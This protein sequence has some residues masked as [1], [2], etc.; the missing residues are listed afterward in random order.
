MHALAEFLP[1]TLAVTLSLIAA[2]G[3]IAFRWN[4]EAL[5][6]VGNARTWRLEWA[7]NNT[8]QTI[9]RDAL[10][11]PTLV[12]TAE[13][14]TKDKILWDRPG[15]Q[16]R[17]W[18]LT[19]GSF[20]FCLRCAYII[21]PFLLV[22][23]WMIGFSGRIGTNQVFPSSDSFPLWFRI[24]VFLCVITSALTWHRVIQ[25]NGKQK[26]WAIVQFIP[27]LLFLNAMLSHG[28]IAP[29][30][31]AFALTNLVDTRPVIA[32]ILFFSLGS[33]AISLLERNELIDKI[34]LVAFAATALRIWSGAHVARVPGI[35]ELYKAWRVLYFLNFVVC[36]YF[37]SLTVP[38]RTEIAQFA[39]WNAYLFAILP[40]IYAQISWLGMGIG[41]ASLEAARLG[42]ASGPIVFLFALFDI[43]LV[44]AIVPLCASMIAVLA[45]WTDA[46]I[47]R[48]SGGKPFFDF[49]GFL[50][51]LES[52]PAS[53]EYSWL[54]AVFGFVLLPVL[55][56]LAL[57]SGA[58]MLW[59]PNRV[60][61]WAT[62]GWSSSQAKLDVDKLN[63][64]SIY[65]TIA[66]IL[67]V[68][69]LAISI[70]TF[71]WLVT[72]V[73]WSSDSHASHL[74]FSLLRWIYVATGGS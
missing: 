3:A 48:H 39:A 62:E 44:V 50:A 11:T 37:Y 43:F 5:K 4:K 22:L 53:L 49:I 45:G 51:D 61:G 18:P 27:S 59:V 65:F 33:A 71:V 13:F 70:S 38:V 23:A 56:H 68:I 74:F 54:F 52:N 29:M 16:P 35:P 55:I 72:K 32:G 21:P 66:P 28:V 12:F 64:L 26:F 73:L 36:I 58:L 14:L 69:G 1:I 2:Y 30:I 42:R 46:W 19:V 34:V 24:L 15:K 7:R 31:A 8:F 67:G 10:L 41:R 60:V 25:A 17:I 9:Y 20:E 57:A 6:R 47:R 40:I 63:V